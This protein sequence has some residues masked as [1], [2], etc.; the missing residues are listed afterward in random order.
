MASLFFLS[1][2]LFFELSFLVPIRDTKVAMNFPR[3]F[4]FFPPKAKKRACFLLG[5]TSVAQI[6]FR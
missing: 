3:Y 1:K 4:F 2:E 6:F 5:V